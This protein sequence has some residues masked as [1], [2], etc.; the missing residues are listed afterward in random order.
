MLYCLFMGI[1][2][3][4]VIA[5][6][7]PSPGHAE[8]RSLPSCVSTESLKVDF[9][10]ERLN[11][12]CLII[13]TRS[14][15]EEKADTEAGRLK[16]P[17]IVFFQGHAQ[18]PSDAYGLTSGLALKSRSGVVV[19]SVCDTPYGVDPA[20]RGD[21]GKD[22][23]LMETVRWML[24]SRGIAVEGYTPLQDA[25]VRI[26]ESYADD[27]QCGISSGL[28]AVGWSHGGILARR[29]AHFY[30]ASVSALGQVC[31]A[32]YERLSP[33]GLTGKFA[34]E[35][36]RI[37]KLTATGHARDALS[38]AW[39]FTKGFVGDFARSVPSAL[40]YAHPGKVFRTGRDIRDCTVY[41]DSSLFGLAHLKAVSVIFAADDF[42]MSPER[43][44]GTSDP[45]RV[46][47]DKASEFWKR[48]YADISPERT[49]LSVTVLPGTH[50][51]P[52]SHSDLYIPELLEGLGQAAAPRP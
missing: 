27:G 52:V 3:P 40:L 32:G 39:G 21:R 17:V 35:S 42:C 22:V 51:A 50:L 6:A 45:G 11:S 33:L 44:L 16:G 20:W 13:D 31:P 12:Y 23:V 37:S 10:Q 18:R 41:C 49:S 30:P 8:G 2:G 48:Y 19:I 26:D 7:A 38:S 29:F 4:T 47:Q 24:A 25:P 46:P 1:F 34:L 36:L 15:S 43:I 28:I 5:L 9:N 14:E